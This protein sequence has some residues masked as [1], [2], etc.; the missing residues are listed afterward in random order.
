MDLQEEEDKENEGK[1]NAPC[2][3]C[4]GGCRDLVAFQEA[5]HEQKAVRTVPSPPAPRRGG[6][7]AG[8]RLLL[9]LRAWWA[10]QRRSDGLLQT[11]S[12]RVKRGE[13]SSAA[14]ATTRTPN[15]VVRGVCQ[16]SSSSD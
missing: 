10:P 12:V 7:T 14:R 9:H 13:V 15:T 4:I 1:K 8:A 16:C 3:Y 5:Q 2:F 11:G 6:A